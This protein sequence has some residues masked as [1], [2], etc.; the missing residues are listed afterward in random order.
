MRPYTLNMLAFHHLYCCP[1]GSHPL[2]RG[3]PA[4]PL[5]QSIEKAWQCTLLACDRAV[6][7]DVVGWYR[8]WSCSWWDVGDVAG[9]GSG[10]RKAR[11]LARTA[12][13]QVGS[14]G[15]VSSRQ[16]GGHPTLPAAGPGDRGP[17]ACGWHCCPLPPN[18]LMPPAQARSAPPQGA[19]QPR[20]G[21]PRRRLAPPPPQ[22]AP[23]RWRP[24]QQQRR[25]PCRCCRPPATCSF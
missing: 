6:Q 9:K 19:L 5:L 16:P 20:R 1:F 22:P 12:L 10:A 23:H 11:T 2:R 8:G 13:K 14:G 18:P 4:L 7:R 3:L 17:A 15:A 25:R 24:P 21:A